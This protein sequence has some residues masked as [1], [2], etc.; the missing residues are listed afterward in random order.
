[1][2]SFVTYPKCNIISS[3]KHEITLPISITPILDNYYSHSIIQLLQITL[4]KQVH[5]IAKIEKIVTLPAQH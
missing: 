1:M 5:A 4:H 2:E 3:E